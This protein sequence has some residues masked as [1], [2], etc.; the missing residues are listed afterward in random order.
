[1]KII[2]IQETEGKL[3]GKARNLRVEYRFMQDDA[4][5]EV[6]EDVQL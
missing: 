5:E 4:P 1:M 3:F 2:Q 6:Y